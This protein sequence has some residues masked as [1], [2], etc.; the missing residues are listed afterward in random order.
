MKKISKLFVIGVLALTMVV[1][2]SAV[3]EAAGQNELVSL[4]EEEMTAEYLYS[5]LYKAYPENKLFSNLAESEARHADALRRALSRM[6]ISTEGAKVRD[7]EIPKTREEALAFAL[8]F[9]KEDI[10]MLE[11]LL[12]NAEDPGL[13][14]VLK[15]LL[16][17]SERHYETLEKA[18]EEGI[19]NLNCDECTAG[20]NMNRNTGQ[21]GSQS[22]GKMRNA[23]APGGRGFGRAGGRTVQGSRNRLNNQINCK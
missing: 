5:E 21:T 16:K 7:I 18:I 23:N 13:E 15:N 2:Q 6:D 10:N 14:R 19:D 11:N 4:L 22:L 1:T 12:K 3:A 20:Q 8:A 17:G 9:E